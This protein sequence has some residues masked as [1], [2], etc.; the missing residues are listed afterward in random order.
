MQENCYVMLLFVP[1]D[2]PFHYIISPFNCP[3]RPWGCRSEHWGPD[4]SVGAPRNWGVK[5]GPREWGER[6]GVVGAA[7]E[8]EGE[9]G[10]EQGGRE[11]GVGGERG[12]G[13]QAPPPKSR[14]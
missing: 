2:K 5:W 13:T 3:A 8:R 1:S 14:G 7:A 11:V 9:G 10:A 12:R 4:L 6:S